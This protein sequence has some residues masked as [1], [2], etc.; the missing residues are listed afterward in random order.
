ML[1]AAITLLP[2]SSLSPALLPIVLLVVMYTVDHPLARGVSHAELGLY[3]AFAV[4]TAW[5]AEDM[6]R[7]LLPA[8]VV[9]A[10][11]VVATLAA[12][13]E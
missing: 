8:L 13:A 9:L 7:L 2:G 5:A 11:V 1:A 4:W 10:W 12:Q 3:L 6:N